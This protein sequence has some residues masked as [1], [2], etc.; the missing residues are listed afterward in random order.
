LNQNS[1]VYVPR[2]TFANTAEN[3]APL[4]PAT[5]STLPLYAEST[6]PPA[7]GSYRVLDT[8]S[9]QAPAGLEP[10]RYLVDQSGKVSFKID[11][12]FPADL[13]ADMS[14]VQPALEQLKGVQASTD[15]NSYYAWHK[16]DDTG[17][18]AGRYL[19]DASGV[20]IYLEDPGINGTHKTRPDGSEVT[21]YNAPKAVLMSYI[22]KG[23]LNHQLP[24]GLVLLGVM[25]AIVLEMAGIPSLAFAVG[26]YLPLST[27]SPIL[28]GGLIR[29]FVDRKLRKKLEHLHLS[30]DQFNAEADKSSGVLMASG[31]IAGGALAAII[32]AFIAVKMKS[33]DDMLT[34]WSTAHNSFY[35]GP[36]ADLLALIPFAVLVVI[37]YLAGREMILSSRSKKAG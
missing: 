31:Y 19:V 13:R 4:S 26:V 35:N 15:S 18:P 7:A 21:K 1:T 6:N 25:I 14:Q 28:V 22:I 33:F 23:I 8:L 16:V 12:N 11:H 29:W 34:A 9:G 2:I 5:A 10:G 36:S 20:P 37:L 24:W 17:G 32:I 30:E 27:S 3:V